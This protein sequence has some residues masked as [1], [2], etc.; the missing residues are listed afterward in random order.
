MLILLQSKDRPIFHINK[1]SLG[2]FYFN[3]K[4]CAGYIEIAERPNHVVSSNVACMPKCL[5]TPGLNHN[6]RLVLDSSSQ[7][8]LNCVCIVFHRNCVHL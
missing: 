2:Y 1:V 8:I 7:S 5:S 4:F 6:T 3:V